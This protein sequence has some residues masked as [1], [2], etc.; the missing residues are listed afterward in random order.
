[1]I[2]DILV[3]GQEELFV[4]QQLITL[5]W[6]R[7]LHAF[8]VEEGSMIIIKKHSSF[9]DYHPLHVCKKQADRY[10]CPKYFLYS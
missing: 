9:I 4:L 10:V 2:I 3:V 1:M 8:K 7:H 5:C 6:V